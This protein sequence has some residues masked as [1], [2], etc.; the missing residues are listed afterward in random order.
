MHPDGE[1]RS[2]QKNE[3]PISSD[4]AGTLP[5]Q[6]RHVLAKAFACIYFFPLKPWLWLRCRGVGHSY[7]RQDPP[8]KG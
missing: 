2:V 5:S 1:G 7:G 3:L 6:P 8:K 4:A